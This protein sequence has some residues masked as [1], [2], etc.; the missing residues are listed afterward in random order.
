[1]RRLTKYHAEQLMAVVVV[2][3]TSVAD[4]VEAVR[5]ALHAALR[6]VLD[7][8]GPWEVLVAHAGRVGGWPQARIAGLSRAA[9]AATDPDPAAT[10]ALLYDLAAE[11][12]EVRALRNVEPATRAAGA[13]RA[14]AP[15]PRRVEPA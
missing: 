1:M 13:G 10:R 6:V 2:E 12:N 15:R 7:G 9:Y 14:Y 5:D 4:D 11:L 8:E 3:R